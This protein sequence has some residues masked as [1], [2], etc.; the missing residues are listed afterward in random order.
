MSSEPPL[1]R[2]RVPHP[3]VRCDIRILS[4]QSPRNTTIAEFFQTSLSQLNGFNITTEPLDQPTLIMRNFAHDFEMSVWG[5]PTTNP[6]PDLYQGVYGGLPSNPTEY[7]S[8]TVNSLFDEA[9]ITPEVDDRTVLYQDL[10][11]T[12]ASLARTARACRSIR[13]SDTSAT[14]SR[15]GSERTPLV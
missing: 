10:V 4:G 6:D 7:N 15:G 8:P 1:P 14:S 2:V 12:L 13:S 3:H 5:F 11:A 9:R